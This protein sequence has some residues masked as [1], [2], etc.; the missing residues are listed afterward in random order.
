[1]ILFF[2]VIYFSGLLVVFFGGRLVYFYGQFIWTREIRLKVLFLSLL[3]W[4]A[5]IAAIFAVIAHLIILRNPD[6]N[7]NGK[8]KF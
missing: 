1:M 6:V 2:I 3:S 5:V 8:I 4:A 7:W